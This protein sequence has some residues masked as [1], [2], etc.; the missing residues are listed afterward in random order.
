[1][2]KSYKENREKYKSKD[3]YPKKNKNK[4]NKYPKQFEEQPLPNNK[5]WDDLNDNYIQ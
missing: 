3:A 5:K 4:Q 1:M 2:G